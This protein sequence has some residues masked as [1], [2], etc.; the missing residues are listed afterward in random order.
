MPSDLFPDLRIR[1]IE[2]ADDPAFHGFTST[3]I[4]V[5]AG[6]PYFETYDP[7]SVRGHVWVPH[8]PHCILVA[9]RKSDNVVVGLACCHGVVADTEPKIRDYLLGQQLPFDPR[10][11]IFMS[12]LAVRDEMRRRGLGRALILE[13][14]RWG[15]ERGFENFCMRT[16][17]DG[18]NSRRMYERID[19]RQLPFVQNVGGEGV[20]TSATQRV[21]FWGQ[22]HEALAAATAA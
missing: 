9:E 17:A 22:L 2:D 11:T 5:F 14:F 18:S 4:D 13:R 1:S 7:E 15:L 20:E 16:A 8:L 12:E 3:Y 21:Y 19:A 6:P 10:R